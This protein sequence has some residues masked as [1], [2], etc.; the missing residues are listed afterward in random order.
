LALDVLRIEEGVI[1][2]IVTFPPDCFLP[3]GLPLIMDE[4]SEVDTCP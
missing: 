3:F 4:A 2:E 1:A